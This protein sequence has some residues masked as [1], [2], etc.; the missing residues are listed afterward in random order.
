MGSGAG[1]SLTI[2]VVY[3]E[4]SSNHLANLKTTDKQKLK[5]SDPYQKLKQGYLTIPLTL[6]NEEN[7][8]PI[9][10]IHGVVG[11]KNLGNTCYFNCAIHCLSHTQPLL[12]YML[13]KVFE[14]EI[15]KNSKLGS[16]GQVTECFAQLLSDIWKDER[17]IGMSSKEHKSK[18][19]DQQNKQKLYENWVDPLKLL[20]LIQKYS[21]RFEIGQQ[22][23]CQELLSYLLDIIHEDLNRCKKKEIIKEKDYIGEP[24]EEWAAESWGEHLKI[25]K[26]IVVDLFQGQ[27]KSKVECKTCRYQ[28]HKWEPFLFLNLPIKQQQQQQQQQQLS[29]SLGSSQLK[30]ETVCQLTEC[31]DQFQQEET[32]QWKCPKCQ[33]TRDCKK[34]IQ[35]WKLPNILIIHLK[36]F[37][38]GSKQTGKITQKV[39]FPINDLNMSPYCF[40]QDNT[41]YNLY[42][43]AQ[44]HGSL[45]YGHYI[46]ICKHRLDNQWYMYNDDSV[47]KIQDLEKAIVNQYA[48][49]LFYQKQTDNI[50]RQTTTNPSCWPHNQSAKKKNNDD[51]PKDTSKQLT[52]IQMDYEE[53]EQKGQLDDNSPHNISN[54]SIK[55]DPQN[56]QQKLFLY[57][58]SREQNSRYNSIY[59]RSRPSVD[60]HSNN[61]QQTSITKIEEEWGFISNNKT[62]KEM[63]KKVEKKFYDL[64][65]KGTR[66]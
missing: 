60:N 20:M 9:K 43:V 18:P 13:S 64:R 22:E 25:N 19:S 45:Q 14:K 1:K 39:N 3:V 38:Y 55:I 26:S 35:I 31:L 58:N 59:K 6:R 30:Q 37:E 27:L 52:L 50:F 2:P 49:V 63:D 4:S 16:R 11:L 66:K 7:K 24:K 54:N 65:A 56:G 40:E 34:G 36:R 15:N 5:I 42:A 41:I 47:L 29:K 12:D 17:S 44:H 46:S 62:Q 10:V 48:Y 51:P 21:K 57:P 23:D 61:D 53:N 33:E 8:E 28:S 32:I